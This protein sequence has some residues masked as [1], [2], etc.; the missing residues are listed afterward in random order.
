[1]SVFDFDYEFI[2]SMSFDSTIISNSQAQDSSDPVFVQRVQDEFDKI[3]IILNL[4]PGVPSMSSQVR[5]N[6][7]T[8]KITVKK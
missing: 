1:M 8:Y 3:I 2:F 6:E 7:H 4:Y 5:Y